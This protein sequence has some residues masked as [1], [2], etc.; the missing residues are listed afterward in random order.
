MDSDVAVSNQ[1]IEASFEHIDRITLYRT[2]K[3]FEDMGIVHRIVDS[4][5]RP[6]YALCADGCSHHEHHDHHVHFE[7][8]QCGDVTCLNDIK[9][10]ELHLPKGYVVEEVSVIAK[11]LCGRCKTS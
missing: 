7:C 1:V 4:S 5:A 9:T 11:G 10:P 2:L 3:T 8:A 6:K